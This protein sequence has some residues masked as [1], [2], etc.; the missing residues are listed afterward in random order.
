VN[1]D[2]IT[3]G[4][5]T[6]NKGPVTLNAGNLSMMYIN[7]GIRRISSG[8]TELIRMIYPAVRGRHWLTITPDVK[9]EKIDRSENS[10]KITLDCFYQSSEIT[11]S[12]RYA[13]E[14]KEDNTV[15]YEMEGFINEKSVRNRI[16]LCVLHPVAG[17]TG[18]KCIIGHTDGGV[19]EARFPEAIS[20]HQVFRDI[21]SMTWNVKGVQCSIAFEGDIFETE[22]QRNWT[23]ASFKTYST[24]LSLPYPVTLA[25]GATIFQKVV[26]SALSVPVRSSYA[27]Q[28][29][30]TVRF[31]PE[32]QL[33]LPSIGVCR[34]SRGVSL[35]KGEVK[36]IR[37]ASFDHYR[38]DIHLFSSGWRESA[39]QACSE[40]ADL[41]FPLEMALFFDDDASV[42]VK[43]FAE[44]FHERNPSL[45]ALL[46]FHRSLPSFPDRLALEVI[47]E[48]RKQ[49]G[50]EARIATGTNASFAQVNRNRPGDSGNDDICYA[51]HPQEHA[52]DN[53]TLV[54]NLAGQAYTVTSAKEFACRKGI[55]ISPVTIQRRFNANVS[56]YEL[57]PS[58]SG[59]PDQV[60]TRL[61][62]LFGAC[63]TTGSI[64]YLCEAGADSITY[65]ETAGERGIIQGESGS[66]W[67]DR[68]PAPAGMIF[69]V[70]Y[71]FR[72]I[73]GNKLFHPIRTISS[74]PLRVECFALSDGR[75]AKLILV[76]FSRHDETIRLNCCAGIFRNRILCS[77][78]YAKA[79]SDY[80]WKGTENQITINSLDD[81]KIEPFSVNFIEG[82]IKH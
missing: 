29:R 53:D 39:V 73:L 54:E 81:F 47:P 57:P 5:L 20:P 14:G 75:Q 17:I 59:F 78:N 56:L 19:E 46:L 66:R 10:F 4:S 31:L 25:K 55:V 51:I 45:K 30:V 11:L 21:N 6:G 68:F 79:V 77:A 69:P 37:A 26:F 61:M 42:Q 1:K 35:T 36:V 76:N 58:D 9:S 43:N 12:A 7:G 60:D 40:S 44:W 70:Y 38:A 62:S 8:G 41:G 33:K 28:D 64:K 49:I 27:R 16:G 22:D 63:W 34:S 3:F 74:H 18:S 82:W 2:L 15:T 13:I 72:Y 50:T 80:R 71:I 48:L 65:Y 32:E 52:S 67:P 23:D 24:P